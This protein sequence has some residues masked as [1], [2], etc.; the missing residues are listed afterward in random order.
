MTKKKRKKKPVI[1]EIELVE[2]IPVDV[3]T[4]EDGSLFLNNTDVELVEP[5]VSLKDQY[6]A[7]INTAPEI[8]NIFAPKQDPKR[9]LTLY[10]KTPYTAFL[11]K[12]RGFAENL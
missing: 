5:V 6:L 4:E 7:I 10:F 11:E 9:Q 3:I 1:E 12:L 2:D 8:P